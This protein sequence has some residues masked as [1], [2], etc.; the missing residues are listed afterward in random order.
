MVDR[1]YIENQKGAVQQVEL[2]K[3]EFTIGRAEDNDLVLP[4]RNVSRHHIRVF[5][6][7]GVWYVE[8]RGSRYGT[9]YDGE[10]LK[11]TAELVPGK[12]VEFA[13]YR[14]KL[15]DQTQEETLKARPVDENIFEADE[16]EETVQ[17]DFFGE[18]E[19]DEEWTVEGPS[20]GIPWKLIG[21]LIV[22]ALFIGGG[23]FWFLGKGGKSKPGH[24]EKQHL[25]VK[26]TANEHVQVPVVVG[27]RGEDLTPAAVRQRGLVPVPVAEAI[28]PQKRQK[29]TR[30]PKTRPATKQ[31][32][33]NK[34][35][36]P[37]TKTDVSSKVK[38]LIDEARRLPAG[39]R[40]G[41]LNTCVQT[42][43]G[44]CC[45]GHKELA[46]T[47]QELGKVDL[48]L[49]Q[50]KAYSRCTKN[51]KEKVKAHTQIMRL[52]ESL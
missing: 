22:L 36:A 43:H 48:S 33:A 4:E 35:K 19:E 50:W 44:A 52:Q 46:K 12:F 3:D 27:A 37:E 2:S 51:P 15:V 6:K 8:D 21:V 16:E 49:K 40:I 5:K 13:G 17:A 41:K 29:T 26:K 1:L 38:A 10:D 20:G 34:N 11:G 28:V 14:V 31:K 18:E 9:Q 7:D 39:L 32:V 25:A 30:I 47:Y 42:Y 45:I 23:I 24:S